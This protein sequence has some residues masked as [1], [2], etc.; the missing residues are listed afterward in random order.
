M[1]TMDS[2]AEI[3]RLV[4]L[5][6]SQLPFC[7]ASLILEYK[8]KGLVRS[9][10]MFGAFYTTVGTAVHLVMQNYLCRQG[11]FLADYYCKHCGTYYPLSHKYECCGKPTEYEEVLISTLGI[12]GHIDAIFQDAKGNYWILDFKTCS[13][14]GADSK[15]NKPGVVYEEQVESY[16]YL[17]YRQYGI[18][19]KGVM[20]VFIPRDNPRNPAVW[21]RELAKVHFST[22][23]ERIKKY[24]RVHK[25]AINAT[26]ITEVMA[27]VKNN[28][29][30]NPYC[31]YCKMDSVGIRDMV[32]R[33]FKIKRNPLPMEDL[34]L[35]LKDKP[36]GMITISR[37]DPGPY[38]VTKVPLPKLRDLTKEDR[39]AL[40]REIHLR[41]REINV[42]TDRLEIE[43]E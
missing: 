20:L 40:N 26:T 9:M 29:C 37:F 22:V 4:N 21:T 28:K 41:I 17:L 19:V 33:A 23:H 10:D 30:A 16:A 12:V 43:K 15:K 38:V 24:R 7:P 6:C 27:L 11:K 8:F 34:R 1:T 39:L 2:P 5:R 25:A 13:M 36:E 14:K 3:E 31:K 42:L 35:Q 32:K 18:K